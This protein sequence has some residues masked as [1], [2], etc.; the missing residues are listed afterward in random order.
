MCL[1]FLYRAPKTQ[2]SKEKIEFKNLCSKGYFQ[3]NEKTAHR[4]GE[5]YI[6]NKDLVSNQGQVLIF[7]T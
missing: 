4:M 6:L 5:N 3:E 1:D 7:S 2:A